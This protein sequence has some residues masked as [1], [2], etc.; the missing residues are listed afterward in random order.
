MNYL[1]VI[2]LIIAKIYDRLVGEILS[3]ILFSRGSDIE[4][5]NRSIY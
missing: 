2:H 3:L 4:N 1:I 5:S